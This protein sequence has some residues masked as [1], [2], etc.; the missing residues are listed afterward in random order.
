MMK[1]IAILSMQRGINYGSFLQAFA[2]KKTVEELGYESIFLDIKAGHPLGNVAKRRSERLLR[3]IFRLFRYN[4]HIPFI[5]KWSKELTKV[6]QSSGE[7]YL[8]FQS[9]KYLYDEVV[10]L[11]IIGS[12]E[13]FNCA[14]LENGFRPQLLGEGINATKIISYAASAGYTTIDSIK[15]YSIQDRVRYDLNQFSALSVRDENT[16]KLVTQLIDKPIAVTKSLDPVLVYNYDNHIPESVPLSNYIVVF[17]YFDRII[18]A[19]EISVIKDYAKKRNKKII[20]IYGYFKWADYNLTPN[21]FEVLAYF[22]FADY[23]FTDTFH[24]TIFSIK[25]NKP[26]TVFL[27]DSNYNKLYYILDLFKLEHRRFLS[28][29]FDKVVDEKIDYDRINEFILLESNITRDYLKKQ[30]ELC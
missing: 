30:I 13:V 15:F 16:Y 29:T 6:I 3:N 9:G 4:V 24:G 18:N 19:E 17:S 26:F 12:D 23:V 10:D 11:L 28:K 1:K 27:R 8:G 5:H 2:L 20:S 14:D 25:M 7:K 22:R 21:P